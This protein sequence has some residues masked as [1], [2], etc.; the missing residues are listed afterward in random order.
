MDA[1][2]NFDVKLFLFLNSINSSCGDVLMFWISHKLTWVPLYALI[3]YFIIKH[4]KK[5]T[6]LI[7]F[8]IIILITLSDQASVHLF[9]NV[10]ERLRPCHNPEIKHLVHIVNNKCGGTY[11][12]IS[13]H[14]SNVFALAVFVSLLLYKKL[15]Y[16]FP[17]MLF[18]ATLVGYSRIYLGVHYPADVF[19]G[20]VIGSFW[21][22]VVYFIWQ[23][24][25]NTCCISNNCNA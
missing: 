22:Y 3:L 5:N 1:L 7:I 11:G 15:K 25:S 12:F 6:Y 8:S 14:A 18:W 19:M 2:I 10:F 24:T 9:K 21:G 4:Y 13:S 23:K 17:F 20:A 16:V